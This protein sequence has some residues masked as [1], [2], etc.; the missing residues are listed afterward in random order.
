MRSARVLVLPVGTKWSAVRAP[1]HE[2]LAAAADVSGPVIHVPRVCTYFL[3]PLGA[4]WSVP[5]TRFLDLDCWLMVPTPAVVEPPGPYWLSP[6]DGSGR[7]VDP[8]RLRTAFGPRL[9][10]EH[11]V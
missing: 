6:P 10:V 4:D 9:S 7:L 5:G 1:E 8:D 2:G 11:F 3:V